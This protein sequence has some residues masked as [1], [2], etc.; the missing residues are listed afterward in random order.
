MLYFESFTLKIHKHAIKFHKVRDV[1]ELRM[2][3]PE[4][5]NLCHQLQD[6]HYLL[7]ILTPLKS[8]T[9]YNVGRPTSNRDGVVTA[10]V[11]ASKLT[12]QV[13]GAWKKIQK[14]MVK[15]PF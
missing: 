15:A 9:S 7:R 10:C 13:S 3:S 11:C 4:I 1:R 6:T 8:A 5:T 14:T 2:K 12:K